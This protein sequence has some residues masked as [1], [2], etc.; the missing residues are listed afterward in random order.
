MLQSYIEQNI[1][2]NRNWA[3]DEIMNTNLF[4]V[5]DGTDIT[6][7]QRMQL[8][9]QQE[10]NRILHGNLNPSNIFGGITN[11]VA[12]GGFGHFPN[13]NPARSPIQTRENYEYWYLVTQEGSPTTYRQ[14]VI[15]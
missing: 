13:I 10:M 11:N 9:L 6:E 7:Y 12:V 2:N 15:F 4:E 1:I 3:I 8:E 5:K 14:T